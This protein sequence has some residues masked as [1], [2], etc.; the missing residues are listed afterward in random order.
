MFFR[1]IVSMATKE[2]E[3]GTIRNQ[4]PNRSGM[5]HLMVLNTA[6]EFVI[7]MLHGVFT[8]R[9]P[10]AK[11]ANIARAA[12]SNHLSQYHP[13][14]LRGLVYG[15]LS[16]LPDKTEFLNRLRGE[17]PEREDVLFHEVFQRDGKDI[18]HRVKRLISQFKLTD[19]NPSA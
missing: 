19:Y 13:W 18:V 2:N 15:A 9:D 11:V 17:M 4:K 10:S 16:S 12:Y 8:T 1:T 7:E 6:L 14:V 5:G 3:N